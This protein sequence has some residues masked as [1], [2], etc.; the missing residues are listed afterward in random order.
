MKIYSFFGCGVIAASTLVISACKV[1]DT[2]NSIMVDN[3]EFDTIP[4]VRNE[5]GVDRYLWEAVQ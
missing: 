5:S 3:F 4:V 1:Q 2:S